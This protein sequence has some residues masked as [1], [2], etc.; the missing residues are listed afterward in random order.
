MGIPSPSM[1]LLLISVAAAVDVDTFQ[2][3][4]G[5]MDGLGGLQVGG[6]GVGAAGDGPGGGGGGGGGGG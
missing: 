2:P 1:W 3:A 5:A 4:G 6:A